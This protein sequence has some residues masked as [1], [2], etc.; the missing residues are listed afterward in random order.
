MISHVSI[1]CNSSRG[2]ILLEIL[3][4]MTIAMGSWETS[5]YAYQKLSLIL[6]QQEAK[7]FQIRKEM[8]VYETEIHSKA[9]VPPEAG[10]VKNDL[11]GVSSRDRAL[12]LNP[13]LE[14]SAQLAAKQIEYEKT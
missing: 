11:T 9:F 2:F 4:V 12:L 7:R 1:H 10:G 5:T 13:L 6:V 8:D 3:V 14:A